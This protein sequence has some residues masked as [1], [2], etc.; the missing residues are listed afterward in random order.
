MQANLAGYKALLTLKKQFYDDSSRHNSSSKFS[1]VYR[2]QA[3][4]GNKRNRCSIYSSR[5]C[6]QKNKENL[7][8]ENAE[9]LET[10]GGYT[11]KL[12][13]SKKIF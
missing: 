11:K 1:L 3:I 8:V 2:L 6:Y 13:G 7:M 12:D 4:T 9:N 10:S 5:T